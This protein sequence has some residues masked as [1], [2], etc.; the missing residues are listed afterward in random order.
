MPL[1]TRERERDLKP[2]GSPIE[3]AIG[4]TSDLLQTTSNRRQIACCQDHGFHQQTER[5]G[6]CSQDGKTNPLIG[7]KFPAPGQKAVTD[8]GP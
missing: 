3:L 2:L 6:G 4:G 8:G 7:V 5:M 1:R